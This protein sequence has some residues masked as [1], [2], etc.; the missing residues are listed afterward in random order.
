ME[1]LVLGLM[2]VPTWLVLQGS[3][4]NPTGFGRAGQTGI[5][6]RMSLSAAQTTH[7]E[8]LMSVSS[9]PVHR[10]GLCCSLCPSVDV[11]YLEPVHDALL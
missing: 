2:L 11:G 9:S 10:L 8:I 7:K 4:V 3:S 5:W 1:L 6:L